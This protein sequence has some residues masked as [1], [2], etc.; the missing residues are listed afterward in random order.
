MVFNSVAYLKYIKTIGEYSE[1]YE[2]E[3]VLRYDEAFRI[4]QSQTGCSWEININ[5]LISTYLHAFRKKKQPPE[6]STR[7]KRK[8]LMVDWM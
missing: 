6:E 2:W 4:V 8:K 3:A 1:E 5:H 7:N